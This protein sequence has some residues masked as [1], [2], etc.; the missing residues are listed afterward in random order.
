MQH[1]LVNG[2]D[3]ATFA[4]DF[5]AIFRDQEAFA[6]FSKFQ[7]LEYNVE[8]LMFIHEC[9]DLEQIPFPSKIKESVSLAIHIFDA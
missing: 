4:F 1:I 2:V 5:G 6:V 8:P 7:E 3:L 9:Q